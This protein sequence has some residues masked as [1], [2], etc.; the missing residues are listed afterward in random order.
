[1]S[2]PCV[3]YVGAHD[4]DFAVRAGGTLAKYARAGSRVVAASVTHGVNQESARLWQEQPEASV[5]AKRRVKQQEMEGC[6]AALGCELVSLG[7]DDAPITI[8]R[9]RLLE[10]ARLIATVRPHVIITHAPEPT[11]RDHEDIGDAVA[12]AVQ[13]ACADG[14][15]R[16][17]GLEPWCVAAV[18][19]SEPGFP[20]VL[21]YRPNVWVDISDVWEA[22]LTALRLA[23]S[24][25][26][27]EESYGRCAEFRGYQASRLSGDE[28]ITH[29]ETFHHDAPWIGDR[30]P[31]E[32]WG[33]R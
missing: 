32:V 25:G 21:D 31:V 15:A 24:H 26:I 6:A 2:D 13:H 10:L 4:V 23:R 7:W 8:D 9:G 14:T 27:L 12:R 19:T 28:G 20:V 1:V 5:G 18:Y 29:A 3:L 22:K 30:L 17:L 33:R 11:N 16:E